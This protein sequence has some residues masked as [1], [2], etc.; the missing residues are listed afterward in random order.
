MFA[1]Y[2][3]LLTVYEVSEMMV[4]GK[5]RI[6]QLLADGKL[7]A[8]RLGRVWKIPRQAVVEFVAKNA[9]LEPCFTFS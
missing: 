3:D 2:G 5:N 8:F 7:K 6:Y 1:E 4:V 9:D